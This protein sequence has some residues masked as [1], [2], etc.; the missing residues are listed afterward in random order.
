MADPNAPKHWLV[1]PA[2]IRG[3]WIGSIL[4]LAL[5]VAADFFIHGHA[6]FGLDGGFGFYAWFGFVT[7]VAMVV[8]AKILGIFL[9]REDTYYD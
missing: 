2:T 1:R 9:K 5:F 3:L 4:V 6:Y 8:G 7:C